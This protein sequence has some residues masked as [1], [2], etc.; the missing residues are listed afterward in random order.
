[1]FALFG[2]KCCQI[3]EYNLLGCNVMYFGANYTELRP[4][5]SDQTAQLCSSVV[6]TKL[7]SVPTEVRTSPHSVTSLELHSVTT[8]KFGPKSRSWDWITHRYNPAVQTELLSVTSQKLIPNY[9]PLQ[10]GSWDRITQ[11]YNPEVDTQLHTVTIRKFRPNCIS[12]D[13]ITQRYNP[14]VET[15]LH[16][17]TVQK[18]RPNYTAL[19]PR[20]PYSSR[21]PLWEPQI[22]RKGSTVY[23]TF[24]FSFASVITSFA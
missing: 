15:E 8:Q 7:H 20:R 1:M 23:F 14:E 13:R 6:W 4:R 5:N 19:Q 10:S 16:I 11:R 17:V 24:S 3:W 12:W 9:T 18:L 2:A 22:E 21:S